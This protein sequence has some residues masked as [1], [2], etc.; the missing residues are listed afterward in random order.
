MY[1]SVEPKYIYIYIALYI[2]LECGRYDKEVK[3]IEKEL[4]FIKD[5]AKVIT[6]SGIRDEVVKIKL[7][8]IFV[9]LKAQGSE[10]VKVNNNN[11]CEI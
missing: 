5:C 4:V 9:F 10:I 7:M 2:Q 3:I 1:N 6:F 8:C 11:N